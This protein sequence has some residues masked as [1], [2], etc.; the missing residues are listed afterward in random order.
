MFEACGNY[1]WAREFL[2]NAIEANASK[3]E[4]GIE[5][6][7]VEKFGLYRR[8]IVDN[9]LGMSKDELLLFFSTLGEGAKRIGGIHDNFQVAHEGF[10]G[11]LIDLPV[12]QAVPAGVIANQRVVAR[13][14]APEVAP[15]RAFQV[16]L[17]M[18]HPVAGLDQG[19]AIADAGIGELHA[20][21]RAAEADLLLRHGSRHH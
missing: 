12:R 1:Q 5:W 3:V 17:Q 9:G 16:L 8:T 7:A 11:E 4:F 18:G 14:I 15:D 13:Q 10:K 2:K 20:I 6:N 19:R 21:R